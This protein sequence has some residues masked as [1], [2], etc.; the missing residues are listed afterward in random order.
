MVPIALAAAFLVFVLVRPMFTGERPIDPIL[1]QIGPLQVRWYGFLIAFSFIPGF[2]LAAAEARRKGINPDLLYDFGFLAGVSGFVGARLAYVLQNLRHF[3]AE[4][5]RI[6]AVWEGGLSM[7]GVIIGGLLATIYFARKIRVPFF[8]F[9]DVVFPALPLGQALGRWGNFFNQELFG[10]PTDVPWKMYVAPEYRPARWA[11]EAYFHPTFLYESL[12]NLATVG[13]LLWYRR[14]PA[15]REGDV[16][17]LYLA[18][19]S[20]GRFWVEFFRIGTPVVA[21]LT[22]AQ[23]VSLLVIA[24]SGLWLVFRNR[25]PLKNAPH[26]SPNPRPRRG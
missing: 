20:L 10:Y 16:L 18:V 24:A 13:L 17:F 22:L 25:Q 19:Y 15:A 7:H 21:G 8:T 26:G 11:A 3:L 23:L 12:W 1:L 5:A 6:V 14:R 9:A 2:Y 4:P